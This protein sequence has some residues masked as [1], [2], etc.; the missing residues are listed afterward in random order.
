[1]IEVDP[2]GYPWFG[3]RWGTLGGG[4][5]LTVAGGPPQNAVSAAG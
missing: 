4:I 1:M 2:V 5:Q 3:V